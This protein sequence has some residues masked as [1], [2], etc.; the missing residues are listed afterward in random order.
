MYKH[1]AY[2]NEYRKFAMFADGLDEF[3]RCC[4]AA[5]GLIRAYEEAETAEV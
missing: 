2:L 3:D 5:S 1:G 4:E